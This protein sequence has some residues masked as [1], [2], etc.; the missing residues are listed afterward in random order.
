M[1]I[2]PTGAGDSRMVPVPGIESIG[3]AQWLPDGAHVVLWANEPAQAF[4]GWVIGTNGEGR[5]PI[6]PPDVMAPAFTNSNKALAPDGR[7]V[8]VANLDGKWSLYP[9]DGGPPQPVA[10]LKADDQ[11]VQWADTPRT[12]Y[13]R[14]RG[15][16]PLRIARVNLDTGQREPWHD[17][18]PGDPAGVADVNSV[19]IASDGRHYAYSSFRLLTELYLLEGVR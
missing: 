11:V 14:K 6:T 13:V 4:R 7:S 10:H 18:M 15:S 12:V 1:T 17:L 8:L 3:G 9:V 5:R 19:I 2:V 16:L